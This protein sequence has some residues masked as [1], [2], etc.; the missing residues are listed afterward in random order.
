MGLKRIMKQHWE[1]Q[2]GLTDDDCRSINVICE[3][4]DLDT[5]CAALVRYD[6]KRRGEPVAC[7]AYLNGD[8]SFKR[9]PDHPY[10]DIM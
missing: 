5:I 4:E 10:C 6:E 9:I 3:E 8:A 2:F 1:I 7:A